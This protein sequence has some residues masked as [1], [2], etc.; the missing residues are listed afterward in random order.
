MDLKSIQTTKLVCSSF[1]LIINK[2]CLTF[3][4]YWRI[5]SRWIKQFIDQPS[6]SKFHYNGV[7]L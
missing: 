6:N 1:A 7:L 2:H 5:F 3:W 4:I